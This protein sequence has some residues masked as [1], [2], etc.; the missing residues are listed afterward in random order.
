M[1]CILKGEHAG[2]SPPAV[3][4]PARGGGAWWGGRGVA[5]AMADTGG[6]KLLFGAATIYAKLI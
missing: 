5:R 1:L 2:G 6:I 4:C 3:S